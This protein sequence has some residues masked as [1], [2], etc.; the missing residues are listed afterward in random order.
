MTKRLTVASLVACALLGMCTMAV[1]Q[2][3]KAKTL[4][5]AKEAAAENE[6]RQKELED[7]VKTLE[8]NLDEQVKTIAEA[9]A[10]AIKVNA[11][12]ILK[13]AAAMELQK[14]DLAAQ[15]TALDGQNARL[16]A[17][18]AALM[19][20][21]PKEGEYPFDLKW[22]GYVRTGYEAIE[23]DTTQTDFI[24]LNDGFVLANARLTVEGTHKDFGF[25]ISFDGAISNA[26]AIN[27]ANLTARTELRDAYGQYA[28]CRWFKVS[29]GRL[30]PPFDGE[31]LLSTGELPFVSRA[32][33]SRG[34]QDVEGINVNGLSLNRQIGV[35]VHSDKIFLDEREFLGVGYF[36][37][38]TN[39]NAGASALNDN[40]SPAGF[41]RLE[42]YYRDW[43]T[44]GVAGYLNPR[45][46]GQGPDLIDEDD[47]GLAVDL[48][49]DTYNVLVGVQY[50]QVDTTFP[51][52][53]AEPGRTARG[54]HAWLGYRLPYGVIPAVRYAFFDPTSDFE[55]E[56][57][58]IS[59]QLAVD[60]LTYVTFGV[61]WDVPER[62]VQF[63][64]NYTLT[65]ENDARALNN[66]WFQ[67]L[68]QLNF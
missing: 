28:P 48:L 23:D 19:E 37:A 7:K 43:I 22:T 20:A 41:G 30:K 55:A 68:A 5:E 15:K 14:E 6:A 8:A 53:E 9:R 46:T 59:S 38:A 58:L 45:T 40:D 31:S 33:E 4:G 42:L 35:M 2:G 36:L 49:A 17:L 32:V 24:G 34:V 39:G 64:A 18:E 57:S 61:T 16:T 47:L 13:V 12:A 25:R 44:L 67:L 29:A 60:E 26:D 10:E 3:K 27:S 62:P 65:L 52:V 56:D 1:A 21:G 66:D 51:D 54:Y 50:M 63:R 11:D